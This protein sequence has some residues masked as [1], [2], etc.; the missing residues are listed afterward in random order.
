M[1]YKY[2]VEKEVRALAL[3]TSDT[4]RARKFKRVSKEFL[5][6]INWRVHAAVIEEVLR[7]PSI[8]ITLK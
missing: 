3:E 1:K 5:E 8:G 2:I 7:H 4:H 6:R